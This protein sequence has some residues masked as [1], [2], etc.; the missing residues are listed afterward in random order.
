[1][2][3]LAI[4]SAVS[5]DFVR[6]LSYCFSSELIIQTT[7]LRI[8]SHLCSNPFLHFT[9][10]RGRYSRVERHLRIISFDLKLE[11]QRR[12]QRPSGR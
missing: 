8:H 11:A 2:H 7:E 3:F 4:S 5:L 10:A 6:D 9:V 12:V 1:M